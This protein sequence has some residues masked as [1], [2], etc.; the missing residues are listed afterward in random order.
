MQ[1]RFSAITDISTA[2]ITISTDYIRP[3]I[4]KMESLST[5]SDSEWQIRSK[6]FFQWCETSMNEIDEVART[7]NANVHKNITR[8]INSLHRRAIEAAAENDDSK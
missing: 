6:E 4:N 2:Y 7:T 3:A 1:G 8:H 5:V